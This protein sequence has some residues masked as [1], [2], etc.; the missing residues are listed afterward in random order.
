M[1]AN[2]DRG[3]GLDN[4]KTWHGGQPRV[5]TPG[6]NPAGSSPSIQSFF[7]PG[8]LPGAND[9]IRK[10]HM[11]YSTLKSRWG[12]TIARCILVAKLKP[13][14]HC[15]VSFT[16]NERHDRRDPDNV[17]FGQKFVLDALR[18][19]K[20]IP[21]DTREFILSLTHCVLTYASKPGVYVTIAEVQP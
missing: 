14:R 9:I 8:P 4:A 7:V 11:V 3:R 16:W 6:E 18:D 2:R 10:H 5:G 15:H 21:D 17:I 12:L 13:V 1:I 19:T 20:I